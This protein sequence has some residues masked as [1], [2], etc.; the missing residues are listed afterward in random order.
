M[1][2]FEE[3]CLFYFPFWLDPQ[4]ELRVSKMW[5]LVTQIFLSPAQGWVPAR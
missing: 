4:R 5:V 2:E 1:V 3:L